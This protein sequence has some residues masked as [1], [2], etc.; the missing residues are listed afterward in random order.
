MAPDGLA[1]VTWVDLLPG[2][3]LSTSGILDTSVGGDGTGQGAGGG[4]WRASE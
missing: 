3:R 1:F 4:T 2:T